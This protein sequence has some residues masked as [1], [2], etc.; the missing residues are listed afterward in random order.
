MHVNVLTVTVICYRPIS[1]MLIPSYIAT[2]KAILT[3]APLH[4]MK[5]VMVQTVHL[6]TV[7]IV[8]FSVIQYGMCG[9]F[10]SPGIFARI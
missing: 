6:S 9:I 2:Y 4:H 10:G 1:D 3:T 5:Y 8:H 7:C